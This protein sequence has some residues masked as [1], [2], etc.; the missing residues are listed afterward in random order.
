MKELDLILRNFQPEDKAKKPSK[1]RLSANKT[2]M[3]KF[4]RPVFLNWPT[5]VLNNVN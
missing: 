4:T 1:T 2:F 3:A 5:D